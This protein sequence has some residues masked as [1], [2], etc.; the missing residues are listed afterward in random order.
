MLV[1]IDPDKQASLAEEV[2]KQLVD[3]AF[4]LPLFQHPSLTIHGDKVSNVST[5]TLDPSMFWNYWEWETK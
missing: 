4:G 3:D 5:T 1:T 2:E